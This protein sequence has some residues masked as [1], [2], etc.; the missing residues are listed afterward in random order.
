M[1]YAATTIVMYGV[2]LDTNDAKRFFDYMLDNYESF[3]D[4]RVF[5]L[6]EEDLLIEPDEILSNGRKIKGRARYEPQMLAD[7]ADSRIH[8]MAYER[9]HSSVV[10]LFI[11]SRG[12]AWSDPLEDFMS[13]DKRYTQNFEK[14]VQ[15]ILDALGIKSEP[16][17][18]ILV[19]Q[20]W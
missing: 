12:Y 13:P 20:V 19:N 16:P 11:A 5:D 8:E 1:G 3:R 9:G 15:P 14:Y 7:D 10:G 17:K 18:I 6:D 4:D 2:R